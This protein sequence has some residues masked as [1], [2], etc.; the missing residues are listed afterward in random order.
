MTITVDPSGNLYSN[1]D[2]LHCDDQGPHAHYDVRGDQHVFQCG[3]C[4]GMLRMPRL[5]RLLGYRDR[6]GR[7]VLIP[8]LRAVKAP[9]PALVP[10]PGPDPGSR[11][12]GP[13][14][15]RIMYGVAVLVAPH[16][17]RSQQLRN[18]PVARSWSS[19]RPNKAR[20]PVG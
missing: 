6:G 12:R 8:P 13:T 4:F 17:S 2:C 14:R 9:L 16:A 3:R 20:G 18:G 15:L 1:M 5:P 7:G 10:P 19:A 11:A